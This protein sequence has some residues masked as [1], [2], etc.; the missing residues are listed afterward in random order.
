M[1]IE[2]VIKVLEDI[3]ENSNDGNERA[4]VMGILAQVGC[5]D[6]IFHLCLFFKVLGII[7]GRGVA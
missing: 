7:N 6:F 4:Q 5:W 3:R 1:R 2:S